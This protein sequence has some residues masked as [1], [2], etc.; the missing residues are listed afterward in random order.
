M[1]TKKILLT[2]ILSSKKHLGD[3]NIYTLP[4]I[5]L[6]FRAKLLKNKVFT[7]STPDLVAYKHLVTNFFTFSCKTLKKTQKGFTFPTPDLVVFSI[8]VCPHNHIYKALLFL[9]TDDV[10]RHCFEFQLLYS[11]NAE[12]LLVPNTEHLLWCPYNDIVTS[13]NFPSALT[14]Q[15]E[16][17]ISIISSQLITQVRGLLIYCWDQNKF[18]VALI[19]LNPLHI[20]ESLGTWGK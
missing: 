18:C 12:C 17:C 7:F 13:M 19:S 3:S 5:S 1:N 9:F 10:Y 8:I 20:C 15:H 2:N 14:P 16:S 11:L 6:L 4:Q